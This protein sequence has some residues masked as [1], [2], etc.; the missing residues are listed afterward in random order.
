MANWERFDNEP[1]RSLWLKRTREKY[2]EADWASILNRMVYLSNRVPLIQW[3]ER[4]TGAGLLMGY[5]ERP[6]IPPHGLEVLYAP[7]LSGI[8]RMPLSDNTWVE[9]SDRHGHIF[10]YERAFTRVMEQVTEFHTIEDKFLDMF[11][12]ANGADYYRDEPVGP[13]T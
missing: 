3:V 13:P 1:M 7:P 4:D 12:P 8:W 11:Y 2:G 10:T 9:V 6:G 5:S